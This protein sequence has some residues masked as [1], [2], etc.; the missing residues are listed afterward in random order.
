MSGIELFDPPFFAVKIVGVEFF[1]DGNVG[2][3]ERCCC[4]QQQAEN[5]DDSQD[6]D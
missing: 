5:G 2:S 6:Y 3:D 1:Q 4:S